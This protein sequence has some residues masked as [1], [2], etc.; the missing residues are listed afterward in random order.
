M[1][2]DVSPEPFLDPMLWRHLRS[3]LQ[4]LQQ[5][6]YPHV[7]NP[8]LCKKRASVALIIRVRPTT[9]T[10]K[11]YDPDICSDTIGTSQQRLDN[12]FAQQ[13][14]QQGEP[15]I[16]FIKRASRSGDRWTG[17][18]AFPGG[19]RESVDKDDCA[20]SI[21]ETKEEIGLDLTA[22]HCMVVGNLPEQVVTTWW[23]KVPYVRAGCAILTLSALTITIGL[24]CYVPTS[25]W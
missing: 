3:V 12:Y 1:V 17:H 21:R 24:W 15:E 25:I 7:P 11:K 22:D 13:W 4:Y 9:P 14:V 18:V 20:T 16:L 6:Q 2:M 23:S 8:P 19:G 10:S 5:N